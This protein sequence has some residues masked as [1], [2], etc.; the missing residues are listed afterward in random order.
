MKTTFRT[1]ATASRI[2]CLPG[3]VFASSDYPPAIFPRS[4]SLSLS[5]SLL[6]QHSRGSTRCLLLSL[7]E[8][9]LEVYARSSPLGGLGLHILFVSILFLCLPIRHTVW[10][11]LSYPCYLIRICIKYNIYMTFR[12]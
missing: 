1:A 3:L 2:F 12:D 6:V 5:L 4:L 8:L 9:E 7:V 11:G 10:S